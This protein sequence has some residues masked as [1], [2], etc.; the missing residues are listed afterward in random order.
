[1]IKVGLVGENPSDTKAIENL[2]SQSQTEVTFVHLLYGIITGSMLDNDKM[3]K[4][5][6]REVEDQKPHIVLFIRDL[7]ALKS[8]KNFEEKHRKRQEFYTKSK[9]MINF[10][11]EIQEEDSLFLLNIYEIEALILADIEACNAHYKAEILRENDV[12]EIENPKEFLQKHCAYKE[13][14]CPEIFKALRID[15]LQQHCAYF[16]EFMQKWD[17]CLVYHTTHQRAI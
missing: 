3:I 12:M 2:L 15:I 1:M 5:L 9:R 14:D 10:R 17:K 13:A 16:Y 4:R 11:K 8:S 6:R 7:D